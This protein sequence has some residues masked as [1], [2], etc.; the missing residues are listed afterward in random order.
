MLEKV[1]ELRIL[2]L[3]KPVVYKINVPRVPSKSVELRN[4]INLLKKKTTVFLISTE[5]L[6]LKT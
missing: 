3:E 4:G 1:L 6:K 5:S 2:T